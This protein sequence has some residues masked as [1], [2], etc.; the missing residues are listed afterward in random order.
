[1]S[2]RDYGAK[3]NGRADDTAAIQRAI[4]RAQGRVS[5]N[6]N[7][8]IVYF[9]P[10]VYS[11]SRPLVWK[12]AHLVGV[13]PNSSVRV[14]W[15]GPAG[16]TM[17]E[18]WPT[19]HPGG[20]SF[21][22]LSGIN[23]RSGTVEPATFVDLSTYP[24][25]VDNFG[26][27]ERCHFAGCTGDAIKVGGWVNAHWTDLRFDGVGGYALHL[28]ADASQ[29]YSS[30]VLDRFTY[31]HSRRSRPGNGVMFVDVS[32]CG[33]QTVSAV[34]LSNGRVEVNEPWAAP[35]ALL[36]VRSASRGARQ[37][38]FH[39]S[40][41]TYADGSKMPNDVLLYR[42]GSDKTGSETLQLT[43]VL[44]T[45]LASVIGGSWP[46]VS[47]R[48][49]AGSYGSLVFN[50]AGVDSV[51]TSVDIRSFA[52]PN[53]HAL[54]I[55]QGHD[56]QPR[57][58]ADA[59]G[60]LRFGSGSAAPDAALYRRASHVLE[61]DANL[62]ALGG[63]TTQAGPGPPTGQV[64]DGTLYVDTSGGKLYVRV[65]GRWLSVTLA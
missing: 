5:A 49:D 61:T 46:D 4:D 31:D 11:I 14:I 32:S 58:Q 41:V 7:A 29:S 8:P 22:L 40:D 55:R 28:V 64:Q 37:I 33:T 12:S 45:G 56:A 62:V 35:R 9:P 52:W 3:A 57:I 42:E 24:H 16:G 39:V 50:H 18:K 13:F 63:L 36:V 27:I 2:V 59:D 51:V 19:R 44:T 47:P 30:F 53:A 26:I 48:L 38:G 34:R 43:N 23:F 60:T 6:A 21:A 25:G 20:E 10:G 65:R 54:Q 1:M 17:V 15:N